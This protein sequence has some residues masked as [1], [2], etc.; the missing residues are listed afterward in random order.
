MMSGIAEV[1]RA[2]VAAE[3]ARPFVHQFGQGFGEPIAERLR[4]DG[5]VVVVHGFEFRCELLDAVSRRHR[6]SAHVIDADPISRGATKSDERS[7]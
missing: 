1:L 3:I 6:E 4:H 7:D 5:R 2:P